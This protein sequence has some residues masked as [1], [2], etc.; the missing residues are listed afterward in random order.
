MGNVTICSLAGH[1][2]LE[3]F[4][5]AKASGFKT[6]ALVVE[7]R[8]QTYIKYYK[9]L[10]DN[11][12]YLKSFQDLT[13][14]ST[15]KLISDKYKHIIFIP[16][17]YIQVYCDLNKF[18][19]DFKVPV[20]GNRNLLKYEEREG[21][22]N[23][24]LILK[25]AQIAYPMQFKTPGQIDRLVIV[26][27]S[28]NA[29][30]YERSFFFAENYSDFKRQSEKLIK[31]GK[32]NKRDLTKAVIEEY[33]VGVQVNFNFFYS[34]MK[35]RLELLGIDTRRQTNIDGLIRLPV[36][37]QA[38]YL[39]HT[40]PS[41]IESGHI[42]VTV[43]ESLLEPAFLFAEKLIT[44]AKKKVKPGIIGPF[45]LQTVIIPGPP[46]EKIVV[47]DLSFRIPGSPGTAYTP[48]S[49]YLF[50]RNISFGERIALEI[51]NALKSK[52]L[53]NILT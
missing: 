43:K 25:K 13:T 1:S 17:R 19:R 45:A 27:V 12:I 44:A 7:G 33:L 11:F 18:E 5:G 40:K 15:V 20:F 50:G 23:Q 34:P 26:K 31:I 39:K 22:S 47:F 10:C 48:Y 41:Y 14:P 38:A 3:I 53:K 16:H 8:D 37:E 46:K 21:A 35:K 24:Y 29:R 6:V 49:S 28:E 36:N 32:I 9:N 4:A 52:S 30:N 42:A 2:A 51:K